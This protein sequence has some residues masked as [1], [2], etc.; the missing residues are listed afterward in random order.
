MHLNLPNEFI[1]LLT[2]DEYF[3]VG[4]LGQVVGVDVGRVLGVGGPEPHGALTPRVEQHGEDRDPVLG[5]RLVVE[6][7]PNLTTYGEILNR[8]GV[9]SFE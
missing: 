7:V 9:S 5:R 3:G 2:F 8:N 4:V 6:N 1:I